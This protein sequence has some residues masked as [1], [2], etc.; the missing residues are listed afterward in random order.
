[1]NLIKDDELIVM[2]DKVALRVSKLRSVG[3][4]F[5]IKIDGGAGC[6]YFEGKGGLADLAWSEQSNGRIVVDG[7]NELLAYAALYHPCNYGILLHI[8]KG[9][10]LEIIKL[11]R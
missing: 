9:V 6:A 7:S 4:G 8:C 3:E 10:C 2:V 11:H 1:L 5:K